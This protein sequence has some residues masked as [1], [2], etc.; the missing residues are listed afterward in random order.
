MKQM[1]H[2]WKLFNYPKGILNC[3]MLG[4]YRLCSLRARWTV[5]RTWRRRVLSV[6]P[7]VMRM[8]HLVLL[9]GL[10]VSKFAAVRSLSWS[11]SFLGFPTRPLLVWS[12]ED[13]GYP[14]GLVSDG[15]N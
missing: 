6:S 9:V 4:L 10:A 7:T 1:H 8:G 14:L 2:A 3:L 13:W 5:L 15:G 12:G 11:L